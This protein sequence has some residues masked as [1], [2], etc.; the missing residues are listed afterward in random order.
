VAV[1][2]GDRQLPLPRGLLV[3]HDEIE[4]VIH[5]LRSRSLA[6]RDCSNQQSVVVLLKIMSLNA[7]PVNSLPNHSP[8]VGTEAVVVQNESIVWAFH[9]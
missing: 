7:K 8:R 5:I 6:V 3:L 4:M 9:L 2:E 1:S